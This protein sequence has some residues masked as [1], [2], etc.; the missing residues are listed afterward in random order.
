MEATGTAALYRSVW[1]MIQFLLAPRI[2]WRPQLWGIGLL[3][4]GILGFLAG[5]WG[6]MQW[7]FSWLDWHRL[8][9]RLLMD[10]ATV[11]LGDVDEPYQ[12]G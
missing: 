5:A 7:A 6:V 12:R 3:G 11:L 9:A 4:M 1:V 8:W 2:V 10:D